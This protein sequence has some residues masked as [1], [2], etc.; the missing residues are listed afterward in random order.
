ML[1]FLAKKTPWE[2]MINKFKKTCV[3]FSLVLLFVTILSCGNS[4]S[5]AN[6]PVPVATAKAITAFSFTNPT[7]TGV[8]DENAKTISVIVPYGTSV[9]A[10]VATFI[11]TGSSV[12]IGT[13]LQINGTTPNDFTNPLTYTVTATDGTTAAYTVTVTIALNSAK[14][15]TAFSLIG[16]SGVVNEAAKTINVGLPSGTNVT[17]L[18]AIFTTTGASITV[19]PTLQVSGTTANDFT[20]P[21]TYTVKA[22]DGSTT[23]YTITV[24]VAASST[25]AITAFSFTSPAVTGIID[26]SAK[27]IAMTV[28]YGT[29]V[30]GLIA[31][32]ITTGASVKVGST[33]QVSGTTPNN[34][35]SAVVYTVTAANGST[36]AYTVT[37]TVALS[38]A[39]AITAYSFT[40]QAAVGIIDESAKTI[41]V[42][43]PNGI[44]VS[45][46]VATFVTTGASVTVGATVQVS[47]TTPNDFTNPVAYTVTAA[48]STTATY[49]VT[50]TVAASSATGTVKLPK[51]GQ[52]TCYD[53]SGASIGCANTGQN[54]ELQKGVAW[55]NPRFTTKA[56]TS[57]TDNL[58]GL[59]WVPNG[60]LM[61]TRD[62]SFDTDRFGTDT[63]N[64]G[65]VTW[66]HALDYVAKLNAENYLGHND[67]RLPNR[68]ELKSLAIYGQT[69]PA[70]W[71]NTQGFTS[72]QAFWYWSSTSYTYVAQDAWIV[73]MFDGDVLRGTKD[74]GLNFCYVWPVRAGQNT[75]APAEQPKT[76][77]TI[78]Y[79]SDPPSNQ[80]G[81]VIN[82]ANTGQDGELQKGV[83]WPDPRFTNADNST[84]INGYVVVDKLTG[85][86]WTKDN[87]APGPVA[88]TPVVTKT[89]QDALD[90]V[91]C[92]NINCYLGYSDWRLP[93][94][95]ELESLVNVGQANAATWLQTS[96][97]TYAPYGNYWSSTSVA[98]N[99][100]YAWVVDI[101]DG[102]VLDQEEKT[103]NFYVWP[104]RGGQ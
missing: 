16:V 88:C 26:E 98:H 14:A 3:V 51:T 19:G 17:A 5:G 83:A 37:V 82:C 72:A 22:A 23:A 38:S 60:N 40:S 1:V 61:S 104:V 44:H 59:I 55:P 41:A 28:P 71:L 47:G 87:N 63:V 86:M 52:T 25:K 66:Q 65:K 57:V 84:P 78:C 92:L 91:A 101:Y 62:P 39:K 48:D 9:T 64:D 58:T 13:T 11:S 4:G 93:D 45:A 8:I 27:T 100:I 53:N 76:G 20:S 10:L 32:F 50:V 80:A 56:D 89:W 43:V 103:L 46:L 97:F 36:M 29:D 67:W 49:S 42:N 24:T 74:D 34:F 15:I 75:G 18:V 69:N 2:S 94:V 30:T 99:A 21:A 90:Y 68:T 35:T 85:L 96:G 6:N 95:N 70:T 73:G 79:S 81:T 7:T 12:K 33:V 77:Q 102:Y 54:G 31:T